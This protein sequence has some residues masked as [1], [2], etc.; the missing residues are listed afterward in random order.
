MNAPVA[1]TNLLVA[2]VGILLGFLSGLYLGL[3]FH[4]EDWLG[5]YGTFKRRLYR[6]AHISLFGL[7][8]VNFVF[9]ITA[10]SL[11][12]TGTPVTL[13]SWAFIVGAVSM[14]LCCILMAH[15]PGARLLFSLPVVS[16][17]LG[18]ILTVFV[19]GKSL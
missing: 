14:P 19:L 5:G 11:P 4:Q 9:S 17:L 10:R 12:S 6:L 3:N 8:A 2:W 7:G 1:Q 15:R 18:G 13:A 16:L